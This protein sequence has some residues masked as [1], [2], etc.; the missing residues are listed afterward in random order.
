MKFE[1]LLIE[2]NKV[3]DSTSILVSDVQQ[4]ENKI[5]FLAFFSEHASYKGHRF[6]WKDPLTQNVLIG[7]GSCKEIYLNQHVNLYSSLD[8]KWA[9]FL[10][11]SQVNNKFES[12]GVGPI[13][14]GGFAFDPQKQK[15]KLWD[16]YAAGHFFVPAFMLSEINGVQYITTNMLFD[17]IEAASLQEVQTKTK[18][19][20]KNTDKHNS[21]IRKN[22][23]IKIIE[24]NGDKW[25][26]AVNNVVND[27]DDSLKKVVLAR[28]CRLIFEQEI[29]A[30]KVLKTLLS[31][32]DNSYIFALE[33]KDNCFIGASPE[34]LVK[35]S[36]NDVYST[37]LAGSIARGLNKENDTQ[38]GEQLLADRKNRTEHQY[39]V[40][41]IKS[42]MEQVC[43][44]I[45]IPSTPK[46]MKMR[47]IQHL[48]TPVK[49]VL[50]KSESILSLIQLLHP[51]P[52]LGGY[53]KQQAIKKIREEEILDRG[54]YGAPLGWLDYKGDGEF[55][56][57]IR[58]G[59]IQ[60]NE[61]SIFAGCGIVAS[62]DAESEYKETAIKFIPMLSALGGEIE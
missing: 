4:L 9:A 41:M 46:I 7:L 51:T 47:D 18:S 50:K 14:F 54:L 31:E 34:R 38:L 8:E 57:S 6:F 61:A 48:Y 12:S 19:F 40:N 33:S 44:S 58:S 42:A 17:D 32:Q 49:G 43:R 10:Q 26:D 60:N 39:V 11:N 29:A 53:P 45:E 35:K 2:N 1:E 16:H 15:T 56:V 23:L 55:A 28:E 36:G 25:K 62:S 37:C 27:L 24:K 20:L 59:L 22:Q 30:E 5:D 52:A 13:L 3:N 21:T